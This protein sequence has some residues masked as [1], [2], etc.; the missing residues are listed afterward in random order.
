MEGLVP[1]SKIGKKL[2]NPTV[3]FNKALVKVAKT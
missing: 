2:S 3:I 1:F